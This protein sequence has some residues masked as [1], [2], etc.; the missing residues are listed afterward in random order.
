MQPINAEAI[1]NAYVQGAF[2]MADAHGTIRWYTADPR[3]ILPIQTFR[4][5]RSVRQ[6]IQRNVFETRINHN[7]HAVMVECSR[8]REG[9][10]WISK[11]L[12]ELYTELHELGFAHSVESWQNGELV[13]GLYGVTL[14]SAFFGESMFHRVSNASK[15]ALVQLVNRLRERDFKLLDTQAV[16]KHLQTLGCIEVPAREYKKM[17]RDALTIERNFA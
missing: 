10:T 13:G 11:R 4:A 2:P 7:F 15:V 9:G 3:G 6:L 16:T 12:I 17:L 1:L 5:P 14:G 8:D